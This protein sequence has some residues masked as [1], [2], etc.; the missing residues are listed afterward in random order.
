MQWCNIQHIVKNKYGK[1]LQIILCPIFTE[2]LYTYA[3][4]LSLLLLLLFNSAHRE[5]MI[6]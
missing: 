3:F 2:W 4:S 1:S 5:Q 6:T